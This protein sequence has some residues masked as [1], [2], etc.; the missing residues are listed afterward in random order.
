MGL[1]LLC[2]ATLAKY[3][4]LLAAVYDNISGL[5]AIFECKSDRRRLMSVGYGRHNLR[6]KLTVQ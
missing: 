6:S 4:W 2:S 1:K 3:I 5:W